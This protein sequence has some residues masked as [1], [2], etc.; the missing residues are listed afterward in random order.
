MKID[1]ATKRLARKVWNYHKMNQELEKA[2][3]ILVLGSHDVRVA[4]RGAQLY[5]G[6]WAP[7]LVFSGGLGDL[8]R[9]IWKKPEAEKFA[10]IAVEMGVPKKDILV[11]NRSVNTGENVRFSYQLLK[12]KGILLRKIILVQ[13]PY[14]ERRTYAT[15]KKQWPD[16]RT[17]IIVT[18]PQISFEQYPNKQ[19]PI[20]EVINLMVGDLQRIKI[21]SQKG[22]QIFQKI[23]ND[24][25]GAYEKLVKLGYTEHL[26]KE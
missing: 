4:E 1:P 6:G 10:K 2:D 20:N 24:A 8:T 21:Y 26:I 17:K 25:W 7:L 18:S 11:E 14:M 13:K 19:I 22:F 9:D 12:S 5:L 23:P 15:F 3:C 16:K